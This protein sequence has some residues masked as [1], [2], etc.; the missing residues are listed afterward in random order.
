MTI[1]VL[2]IIDGVYRFDE[3]A[4]TKDFTYKTLV[5]TLNADPN[6]NVAT[7]HRENLD[8]T[9]T[10]HAANPA[11]AFNLATHD[12]MQYDVI[13]LIGYHGR[14]SIP[15]SGNSSPAS[16]PDEEIAA[17]TRFMDAGGGVFAT[18]DHDSIGSVMCGHIPRVRAMRCWF[19]PNDST[20]P[21]P[22]GFPSNFDVIGPGR[23]DTVQTN[24]LG[25]YT[26]D[27]DGSG[28]F[29]YFENQSD[30]VP[31]PIVPVAPTHPI[32]RHDGSDIIIYPDHMHEGRTLGLVTIDQGYSLDYD[33]T[34]SLSFDGESFTEFPEVAGHRELPA[35]IATGQS[36]AQ[37]NRDAAS[38]DTFED[39]VGS[40]LDPFAAVKTVNT[41][42]TYDGRKSGVGRVVTG[43]TFHHYI[44]I[45][46]TGDIDMVGALLNKTGPDAAKNHGFNDDM[47]TF[48][49]IKA[50]FVNITKWL[51][52]PKPAI[53][54][55]LERST[56]SQDEVTGNPVF[57]A[58]V[59]V[60][61]QG[62][63]P[64]QFPGGGIT[65]GLTPAQ[66]VSRAPAFAGLTGVDITPISVDSDDPGFPDRLQRITFTYQVTIDA[67]TAFSFGGNHQDMEVNASLNTPAASAVLTDRAWIQL[68]KSANPFMLD[69]D[70]PDAKTWLSSD[71]RVFRLTEGDDIAG[72]TLQMGASRSDA[73]A[74]IQ[75]L[76]N[77][78]GISEFEN[79]LK[80]KQSES[81]LS[82][83]PDTTGPNPKKV[84]NFAVARVRLNGNA[85]S[86]DDVRVFFRIFRSQTTAALTFNRNGSGDPIQGYMDNGA[87]PPLSVPGQSADSQWL[88]IPFYAA[89]RTTP[90]N[91]DAP[92][93]QTIQPTGS[94]VSQFF[95]ALIDNNLTDFSMESA[96][97][98]GDSVPISTLLMNEHQCLVA[99]VEYA[100]TPIPSGS[101]PS[102]S[103]KLSQRNLMVTEVANPGIDASRMGLSTFE[104]EATPRPITAELPADELFIDWQH[105]A[106]E[107]TDV[108]IY[109]PSWQADA[110]IQLADQMYHRHEIRKVDD[111]TIVF[112]AGGT[113]Y[114]PI[115]QHFGRQNG[116][117]SIHFPLGIKKGQR[118]DL[119]IQQITNNGRRVKFPRP[120][121][122]EIS[123][124]EAVKLLASIDINVDD[125]KTTK[126][127]KAIPRGVYDLGNN[128]TLI[129]D[130]SV[131]DAVGDHAVL[132]QQPDPKEIERARKKI[133]IWREVVGAFQVSIPVS[134]KADMVH[135]HL[136][137]LSMF[138]WRA[139][140]L[141]ADSYWHATFMRYLELFTR[142]VAAL[143]GDINAIPTTPDGVIT[144]PKDEGGNKP[145]DD[146]PGKGVDNGTSNGSDDGFFEPNGD[147][148]LSETNGLQPPGKSK[149]RAFS[150]KVSGLIFDHF[151][152]FEGF[153]LEAYNGHHLRFFSREGAI[154]KLARKAW[155]KRYVVT[156]ITV[157]AD[158]KAV[159][160]LLQRGYAD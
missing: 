138:R 103:D 3:P 42:S 91:A 78:I 71:L 31:Q 63:K 124:K 43:S 45:N 159:R 144:D 142:K 128:R 133:S 101:K 79:E 149:S 26:I 77:N 99:Q 123:L 6:M 148:W 33:Y 28:A 126:G 24:P 55:I 65:A 76:I 51:A 22:V 122:Q 93:E 104:I 48:N 100:G 129:T 151:G 83:L 97:G 62:V 29:V 158:S 25:D 145:G 21:M 35:V 5:D 114:V 7:A 72:E 59:L 46:L 19:G 1:N 56:F 23:A 139:E 18:G 4:A 132:I 113:K 125:T 73:N 39:I 12:L 110:V 58:A 34:Q 70:D 112:P 32:L 20:S 10:L 75:N 50:V 102:T 66:L 74:F 136:R 47:G 95:G 130:L 13:W 64:N 157:S 134:T 9:A 127:K 36:I 11:D 8:T 54:I 17:L 135:R 44:D 49:Q 137:L 121:S 146:G 81:A 108:K 92:N 88:S 90:Q 27:D 131:F 98:A 155:L 154:R 40:A 53:E 153:T 107:G 89:T 15:P 94:E 86:A 156:V 68:V 116:V 143:G 80:V 57:N 111:H 52:K 2:I 69:L 106:P 85:A 109:I 147:D 96:P 150:G 120:K 117:I 14:N 61:V 141:K 152:D 87:T 67:G 60:T 140:H 16:I 38:G 37:Q 82:A 84:Y 160:R 119:A 115:P 41:M 30:S 118:Y 105:K